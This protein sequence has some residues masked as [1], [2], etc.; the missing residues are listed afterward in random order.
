MGLPQQTARL[1]PA[2]YLAI[3][4]AAEFRHEY[5]DGEMLGMSGG[6]RQHSAI[7]LNVA[8]E[9]RRQLQGR[10]CQPFDSDMRIKTSPTSYAYPDFSVVCGDQEFDDD[11]GDTLFNP[12]LLIEV[13][14]DSTE[15]YD[16]GRKFASY[17]QISSLREYVLISQKSP[18]VERYLRNPDDT[19]TLTAVL[20]LEASI[21]LPTID[22]TLPL[23]EIYDRV[24]FDAP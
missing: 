18:I 17:R 15:A 11:K 19:W 12:T 23:A 10:P 22:V 3:E 8:F 20:G 13:L 14:S 5:L 16:R 6:S 7:K 9:L 24:S 1:T 21:H 2:E 4:R